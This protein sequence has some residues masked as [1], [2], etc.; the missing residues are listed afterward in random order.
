LF[1]FIY[2]VTVVTLLIDHTND[3]VLNAC[4]ANSWVPYEL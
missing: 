2:S 3:R 1:P 4:E